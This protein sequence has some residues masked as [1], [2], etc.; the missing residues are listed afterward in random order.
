MSLSLG[1][2]LAVGIIERNWIVIIGSSIG[3][4]LICISGIV[5]VCDFK[6]KRK[7]I[8]RCPYCGK[9]N[10]RIELETSTCMYS[11]VVYK[12]GKEVMRDPNIHVRHCSCLECG[13]YFRIVNGKT[14]K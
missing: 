13:R 8:L 7:S 11:P 6:K 10:F 2:F 4:M 14:E 1:C 12:N 5:F 9:S 3:I